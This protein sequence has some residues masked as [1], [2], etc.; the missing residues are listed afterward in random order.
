M[1]IKNI[2]FDLGG[3]VITINHNQAVK[4]FK[5]IG[6]ENAEQLLN[7]YTQTDIFGDLES[8]KITAEEFCNEANKISTKPITM[9]Q[10]QYAWMGYCKELPQRNLTKIK[11][12]KDKGYNV[13][14][15]SNTNP[16]VMSWATSN[17]FDG[18]GNTIA[19]YFSSMY[20]SYKCKMMKPNRKL[21]EKIINEQNI[22]PQETLFV[23][24]GINNINVAKELNINTLYVKNGEDWTETIN[25]YIQK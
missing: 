21:F 16:F 18:K 14:L 8:G 2:I 24:D 7:P 25:K 6:I 23:D 1:N 9:Q 4:R 3:V 15:L 11:E 20:M 13:I 10:C 19:H 22:K 17:D 12:L 5:E